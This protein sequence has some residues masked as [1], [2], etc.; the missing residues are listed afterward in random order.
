MHC[1]NNLKQIGL[2]LQNHRSAKDHFPAAAMRDS[3]RP[4]PEDPRVSFIGRLLPYME[5]QTLY[6]RL[7]WDFGWERE[8]HTPV[9]KTLLPGLV[10]PSKESAAADYYYVNGQWAEGSGEF[11]SH[12]AAVLGPK[13]RIPGLRDN[14]PIDMSHGAHGGFATTGILIHGKTIAAKEI[15]DGLS[16]TFIVGEMAWDIGEFESW[17]GGLSAG[18][19]NAITAKNLA[20]PLNS[21]RF[22]RSLNFLD[23]NDTSFGSQHAGGGAHFLFADGSVHYFADNV[24][25]DVLKGHASRAHEEA[26]DAQL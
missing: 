12:Y 23:I 10:C 14:Y 17:L 25:L 5:L 3:S 6:G 4:I 7:D 26:I 15:T 18:E 8:V 24:A 2:A 22:D 16:N 20:H 1:G 19:Q 21:Y 9:R 11:A 13:G